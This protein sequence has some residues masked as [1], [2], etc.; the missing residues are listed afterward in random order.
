M[1]E[2]LSQDLADI[3]RLLYEKRLTIASGGNM[4]VRAGNSM[5]ITPSG[6]CKGML[7]GSDMIEIDISSGEIIGKGKPS[8]ET[9]FHLGIY[10][11]RPDVNA[12][13]HCHPVSC[14][15]LAIQ[16][17]DLRTNLTPE[18]LMI[19]G[20]DVPMIPYDT[21]GSDGLAEKLIATMG[22]SKACLMQNHG[23]LVVGKDLMDAFFRMETLEYI[24]T[25]QLKCGKVP[26]LPE[27]EIER[28]LAMSK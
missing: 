15:V 11:S 8:I 5:L 9:P 26:G 2:Q 14:T 6:V 19:L 28:V 24:A 25:L 3:G 12:V 23:A 7:S 20:K 27:D 13:I 18:S 4:S 21:P 17:K 1:N 16:K 22:P 10:R